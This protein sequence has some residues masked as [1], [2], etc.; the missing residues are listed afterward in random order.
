VSVSLH[1]ENQPAGPRPTEAQRH[2]LSD[3]RVHVRNVPGTGAAV[4]APGRAPRSRGQEQETRVR[5]VRVQDR[6]EERPSHALRKLSRVQARR[7]SQLRKDIRTR[8]T[9]QQT[10]KGRPHR[11]YRMSSLQVFTCLNSK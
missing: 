4:F 2:L 1:D 10:P 5:V 3:K 11:A 7:L 8:G 6:K 9:Q